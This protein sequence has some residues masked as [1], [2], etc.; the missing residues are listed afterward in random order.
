MERIVKSRVGR[1]VIATL[2]LAVFAVGH[3]GPE[4]HTS[5]DRKVAD[6]SVSQ[7]LIAVTF[8]DLPGA[9][10]GTDHATGDLKALR[11]IN[12]TIEAA[13]KAHHVPAI[14][15][16]N[17]WK[18]QVPSERDMRTALLAEWL[19]A[20][21]TL[22]NHTYTHASL[23]T[24]P[25]QQFEDDTIRGDVVTRA[26]MSARGQTAKYFRYP[27]LDNGSTPETT[28]A[29][30]T[31]LKERGYVVA[32]VTIECADWMF[33]DI[34]GYAIEK[35]DKNLR[36]KAKKEYLE[37]V[38]TTF[39]YL[40]RMTRGLFGRDIPQVLLLHDSEM[41][42]ENLD[43][44]LTQIEKRGYRFISLDAALTDPAYATPAKYGGRPGISWPDRRN[45]KVGR[46]L[47]HRPDPPKWV[48]QMSQA[49]REAHSRP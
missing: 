19:D 6:P 47:N 33:N 42:S 21:L 37:Y 44:L 20:G 26:L 48:V 27:N 43:T 5:A 1:I 14:G 49:I 30:E 31:F 13:L 25:L 9:E 11:K 28:T 22:G 41:N 17:E 8:D 46:E 24:T 40:E 2:L 34:L 4:R 18:L 16:V 38:D 23:Q 35:G 15:F 7:R 12:R 32:P 45:V 36:E 3:G 39:D 10:A 29:F